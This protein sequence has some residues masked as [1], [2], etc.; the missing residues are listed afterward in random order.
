MTLY[1]KSSHNKKKRVQIQ[2][3][4]QTMLL[5]EH[6]SQSQYQILC[7]DIHK[8]RQRLPNI[9]VH[10]YWI[11]FGYSAVKVFLFAFMLDMD[12]SDSVFSG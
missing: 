9:I 7:E 11:V 5:S 1:P 10:K 6:V 8:V 12:L 4:T 2:Y 3:Q